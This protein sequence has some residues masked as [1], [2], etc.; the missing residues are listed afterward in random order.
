MAAEKISAKQAAIEVGTD[1]R[2]LR[3][4]LRS[5]DCPFDAVGQGNRYEFTKTEVKKLKKL[6]IAWSAGSKKKAKV[7]EHDPAEEEVE[8]IDLDEIDQGVEDQ[9][10]IDRTTEEVDIE[11]EYEE[12]DEDEEGPFDEEPDDDDLVEIEDELE[13]EE[14]E[15]EDID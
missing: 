5:D 11:D 15:I 8:E 7:I 10:E 4:F 2:T 3:K 12:A 13:D 6:F 14:L 1:A 9:D